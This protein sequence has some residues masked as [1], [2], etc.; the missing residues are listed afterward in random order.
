MFEWWQRNKI[1]E[2]VV[3]SSPTARS[4]RPRHQKNAVP[5]PK[6]GVSVACNCALWMKWTLGSFGF[7][8]QRNVG[9][10]VVGNLKIQDAEKPKV[11]VLVLATYSDFSSRHCSIEYSSP[12]FPSEGG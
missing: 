4:L 5:L 2:Y 10:G 12:A 11:M 9:M 8:T 3:L 7:C 1:S 6:D